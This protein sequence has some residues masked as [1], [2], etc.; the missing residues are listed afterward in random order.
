MVHPH[1]IKTVYKWPPENQRHFKGLSEATHF[2]KL[3]VIEDMMK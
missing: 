1:V 3:I 2:P